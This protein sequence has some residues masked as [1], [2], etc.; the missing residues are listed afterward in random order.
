VLD[1]KTLPIA[2]VIVLLLSPVAGAQFALVANAG[3]AAENLSIN[4]LSPLQKQV[5]YSSN[6]LLS[7]SVKRPPSWSEV[8]P[9]YSGGILYYSAGIVKFV[10]YCLDG[11][12]SENITVDDY[13]YGLTIGP[14]SKVFDFSFNL[15]ELSDGLH[16]ITVSVFGSYKGDSYDYSRSVIFFV[17]TAPLE[18]KIVSPENKAYNITDI[19]LT[20]TT[21]EPVSWTGYRLDEEDRVT[22]TENTTLKGLPAGSY[23]LTV[24]GNDTIGNFA[25]SETVTFIV[26]KPESPEPFPSAPVAAASVASVAAVGAVLL[27]YFR[28]RKR[29]SV[30]A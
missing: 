12:Q 9:G 25:T 18:L 27:V 30:T 10:R 29:R 20:L 14:S 22:I 19:P 15:T 24:F 28:K 5:Y 1:R 4:I 3:A 21:T 2:L 23:N 8:F 16:N 11:K 13:Q 26:V 6:L 17:D 7:F